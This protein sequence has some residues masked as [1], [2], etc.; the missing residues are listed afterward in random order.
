M[1]TINVLLSVR[2]E[3]QEEYLAFVSDLVAKSQQDEGCLFYAHFNQ[4]GKDNHYAIIENW[5]DQESVD[6]H[7]ATPHL[8]QFANEI[9]NYLE[10]PFT[11]KISHD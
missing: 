11:L 8:Q 7:N 3:K 9:S 6:L 1:I 5:K 10:E 2:K 4:V